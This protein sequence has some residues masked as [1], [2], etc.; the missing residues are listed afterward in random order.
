MHNLQHKA[1]VSVTNF[2]DDEVAFTPAVMQQCMH[3]AFESKAL[4]S[5]ASDGL[6]GIDQRWQEVS[7][8]AAQTKQ[9]MNP[10]PY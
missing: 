9:R 3:V 5:E 2:A 4:H 6:R 10:K 1:S 7:C 8:Y